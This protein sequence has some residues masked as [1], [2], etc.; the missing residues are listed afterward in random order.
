MLSAV[1]GQARAAG[2]IAPATSAHLTA[3]SVTV[4]AVVVSAFLTWGDGVDVHAFGA[5]VTRT[6]RT[7]GSCAGRLWTHAR[8]PQG[9]RRLFTLPLTRGQPR[10]MDLHVEYREYPSLFRSA[11]AGRLGVTT[12]ALKFDRTRRHLYRGVRIDE[13]AKVRHPTPSWADEEWMHENVRL[14]AVRLLCPTA[15]GVGPTAAR[16][17]GLPIPADRANSTLH[18]ASTDPLTKVS[19][20]GIRFHRPRTLRMRTWLELP[21]QAPEDLFV[22]LA[23]VL[24]RN[25]LVALGDA[26][27]GGWHGPPLCS[28]AQLQGALR[29]RRYLRARANIE[30]AC[31]LIRETVDSPQETDLRLWAIGRGLPE[32]TVHPQVFCPMLGRVVE[33]DLGYEQARLALEYEGGHHFESKDQWNRDIRRDEAL[34]AAGWTTL[35]VTS[36]TDRVLLERKIRAHLTRWHTDT[37]VI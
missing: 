29:Q 33:P 14:R 26:M 1:H 22:D 36:R 18:L 24:G 31:A 11:D 20:P 12:H 4:R 13:T 19:R 21:L 37:L 25:A 34:Q 16:L 15:V 9:D 2:G 5:G 35:K 23:G 32:P 8:R 7:A 28:L 10:W 17:Y 30:A 6:H 3:P 27:V